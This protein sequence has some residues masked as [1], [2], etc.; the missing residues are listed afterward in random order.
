M[1][2]PIGLVIFGII[3]IILGIVPTA[4]I[5]FESMRS[6]SFVFMIFL[7]IFTSWVTDS[8]FA[9]FFDWFQQTIVERGGI[10]ILYIFSLLLFWAG[11]AMIRRKS[12]ARKMAILSIAGLF[13]S[14]SIFLLS[15]PIRSYLYHKI[16]LDMSVLQVEIVFTFSLLIYALLL[17]R[18]FM[19]HKIKEYFND[20][21]LKFSLKL[22][23]WVALIILMIICIP[24]IKYL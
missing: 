4:F 7:F 13:L 23:Y 3:N 20:A 15:M 11:L 9:C 16:S 24:A 6:S 2:K 12:Y 10:I 5:I 22:I 14:W 1:R 8:E 17:M 19:S 21:N 18:Y